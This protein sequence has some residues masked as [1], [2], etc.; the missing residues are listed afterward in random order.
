MAPAYA[1]LVEGN[2]LTKGPDMSVH[3]KRWLGVVVSASLMA[4]GLSAVATT[5][6]QAVPLQLGPFWP[7]DL[8]N[9]NNA[10]FENGVGDWQISSNVSTLT[11][12]STAFLH[13][14]ALE[15]V[16]AGSGTSI[17]KLS[18]SSGIQINMNGGDKYR[19]GA[20][21]KM[22]AKPG[23]TTE[24]DLGCY[25]SAGTWLGWQSGSPVSNNS[26]GAWQW[27]EDDITVPGGKPKSSCAYVQGSPR[28]QFTGMNTNGTIHMDEAWFAPYRAALMI[29]AYAPSASTWQTD[30][31]NI[32]PLQSIK[33]FYDS[34]TD[35][36]TNWKNT[37]NLCYNIEQEYTTHSQWPVC[38]I[39]FKKQE[40]ETQIQGFLTGM[41]TDQTV[42]FIYHAEPEGDT[43]SGSC[44]SG[45]AEF[46]CEF[47][48]EIGYVRT[49]AAN[50]GL[51]ENVFSADDSASSE[52]SEGG[53]GYGCSW[54]VPPSYVDF[55]FEDHYEHGWANG[56]NLSVQSGS[57]N[58]AQYW[59]NWL[60]CVNTL[61]KPI[62]LAE[63][64]LCSGGNYCG[65]NDVCDSSASTPA[66]TSTMVADNSYLGTEPSGTSPT[67]L[68]EYWYDNCWQFDNSNGG[69]TQWQDGETQNGGG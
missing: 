40:T 18:G 57:S 47:E 12:D 35:F 69:I 60:D 39:A 55:Y 49:A 48:A 7:G 25:N 17:I 34:N 44:G 2:F 33:I 23:H 50:L 53:A 68:W 13:D 41:P 62:G 27:V 9:M 45:A 54:I 51:T 29:G 14:H 19:V 15:I 28:V 1:G 16:A 56:T 5:A 65:P 8:L 66:D 58:G 52:Y 46:V 26:T 3:L 63:Y 38:L 30:N 36:P 37:G 32:G 6:A 10:D 24:F 21:V 31:S 59:N 4:L 20:Y 61:D 64:G 67:L 42:I 11:T 22:P 43:F